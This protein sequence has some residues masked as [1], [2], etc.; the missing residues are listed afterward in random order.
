MQVPTICTCG[1]LTVIVIFCS[2]M[3]TWIKESIKLY[4]TGLDVKKAVLIHV[5]ILLVGNN[6][7]Y[8][9]GHSNVVIDMRG[10]S[11]TTLIYVLCATK[12]MTLKRKNGLKIL[13]VYK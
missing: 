12:I 5:Q 8:M 2:T 9:N 1:Q 10:N 7:H 11:T 13:T 6:L 3:A 4:M